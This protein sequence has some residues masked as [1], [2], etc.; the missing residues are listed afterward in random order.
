LIARIKEKGI[1]HAE[2]QEF[3]EF[4]LYHILE[5]ANYYEK[6]SY[7]INA[8]HISHTLLLHHNLTSALYLGDLIKKFKEEGWEVINANEAY[9][10]TIFSAMPKSS[11][12]GE[13]L[14]WSMAKQSGNYDHLLRYPGEDGVY[15][16]EK[17]DALGL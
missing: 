7:D 14:I 5:R 9:K 4:Y 15:E 6:L 2:I 10:D 13:S 16:K 1:E 17:M 12:A 3:K 8:R 11:F